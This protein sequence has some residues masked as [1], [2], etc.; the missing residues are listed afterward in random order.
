MTFKRTYFD[1][2][3][4]LSTFGSLSQIY[5]FLQSATPFEENL[6]KLNFSYR[7]HFKDRRKG[8]SPC[9]LNAFSNKKGMLKKNIST[10]GKQTVANSRMQVVLH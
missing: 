10:R 7:F 5:Q 3:A 8:I 4:T 2:N 9:N 1:W 6:R